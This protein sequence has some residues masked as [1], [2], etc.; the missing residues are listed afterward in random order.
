MKTAC[1]PRLAPFMVAV[2]LAM[3]TIATAAI[4]PGMAFAESGPVIRA[5]KVK[6]N[7]HI[8]AETIKHYLK[9]SEGQRYDAAKADDSIKA[10]FATGFFSDARIILEDSTL[11]VAVA[12]NPLVNR[13]AFEGNKEV[14]SETLTNEVRTKPR[15]PL[16]RS[17]VQADV[18]R[19]LDAY[20]RLGYYAAQVDPKTVELDH[21]RADLIFEIK[22]G[23]ET[24]VAGV[25]F[26]GNRSFSDAELRGAIST[27][28]S[29]LL[30]ILK[31]GT[32][33]D[34]DRLNYD[35]ELLRRF[36]LKNGFADVRV[37]S[38]IADMDKE[39][40]G[41]FVTFNLEEGPRY[42]FG[43]VELDVTLPSLKADSLNS[44]IKGQPGDIYNAEL[45]DK[46]VEALTLAA[47]EKGQPFNQVR[48]RL[49]RDPVRRTILVAYVIE[50]GPRAYIGRIDIAGN[51]R[52]LD[53]VIRREFRVA[54]GD[55]YSKVLVEA[56]RQRLIKLGYFKDIKIT[57]E[58]GPTPDRVDLMLQVQ[59][60]Q[61]GQLAFSAGY[62]S[63]QGVIGEV[64]YTE[65]N[66]MGTG[67]YLE[68][69]LSGS[70]SG[71][72]AF[73][74]SWTE[75]RFLGQNIAFGADAF[76][77][78]ADYTASS[79]Y[80]VA[81]YED[82]R[83]GGSLRLAVALD[84]QLTLGTNYTLM[85]DNVYNAD[86][87]ASLAVKQI[88]GP[89]IISSAGYSLIYDTRDSKKKPTRGF[90]FKGTQDLAGVGGDVN[91]IR[92]AAE[93]RGYYPITQ[94]ITLAGRTMGGTI[95]GWGGQ[96]VRVVDAFYKG[97]E[98]IPGFAPAGIGPRD[99]A[100]GD[101]LGGTTFY[102][103]TA[104]LRFPLPFLPQ[105]LGLSGAVFTSA[106]TLFGTD[107]PKFAAAYAAQ[108]GTPNTL[109]VQDTSSL[110]SS[111][112]GSLI[113]DS[114]VGGLRVDFAGAITKAPFDKTQ[115]VGFGYSGW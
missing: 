64:S 48:P 98:T 59:E 75:P 85:W 43:A 69:K 115:V 7:S 41:F 80:V 99:A 79:G 78:N 91:Y 86:P 73:T 114:P 61:T 65:R 95:T 77:K 29:G 44:R 35:R 47:A 15:G 110:R 30:D 70:F 9:L 56:G 50:Q 38:A 104:E 92:S 112:G 100:T 63:T 54:E 36:Y 16:L 34:P 105:D 23:P 111:A 6:G 27:S 58:A 37:I 62:S 107:A 93:L 57:K 84:D 113:W 103:A 18:Q 60:E 21:N 87:N 109:A 26:I 53:A 71:D 68:V 96:S 67:Q 74:V 1:G 72:G 3:A 31:S 42:T 81:G 83:V 90:Y 14:K 82:F 25:N 55:P 97:G 101:A 2:I 49:E 94:D 46:T 11:I 12:E 10:L 39:G 102:S 88:E 28:E 19:I 33:Y 51:F 45:V 8:E 52:T 20:R 22:E 40:K 89:A 17:L 13:V 32:V 24:K 5:V 76:V 66:L 108:H 4:S 106:G